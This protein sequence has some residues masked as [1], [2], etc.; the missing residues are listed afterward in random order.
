MPKTCPAAAKEMAPGRK[1]RPAACLSA[2]DF[3]QA[4]RTQLRETKST[5]VVAGHVQLV[6]LESIKAQLGDR[7][8]AMAS[9]VVIASHT[10]ERRLALEDV[11]TQFGDSTLRSA[12]AGLTSGRRYSRPT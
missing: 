9:K 11:F 1:I 8:P 5:K 2:A 10:I 12:S 6:G 3:S 4:T 7:W